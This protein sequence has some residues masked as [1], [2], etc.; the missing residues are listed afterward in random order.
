MYIKVVDE[1]VNGLGSHWDWAFGLLV[2]DQGRFVSDVFGWDFF[3]SF[4]P[5]IQIMSEV[6]GCFWSYEGV[7]VVVF[8]FGDFSFDVNVNWRYASFQILSYVTVLE[9][10]ERSSAK[11]A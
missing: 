9:F 11:S 6:F 5:Y 7:V 1:F 8:A 3:F 4:A 2:S 10:Y